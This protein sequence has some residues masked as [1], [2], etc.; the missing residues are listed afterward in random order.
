MNGEKDGSKDMYVK[1][2]LHYHTS[3]MPCHWDVNAYR[4]CGHGCR[5][6]FAQY[7]HEYIEAG[8]FFD[9]IFVKRNIAEILDKELGKK[10]WGKQRINLSGVTDAYQP[11]EA[12]TKLMPLIWKVLI[13]HKNPVILSTKSSLILRDIEL[14]SELASL[15]SVCITSSITIM[16]ENLRKLIEPGA[17]P[18]ED[19][20]KVLEAFGKVGCRT[21]VLLTPVMPGINDSMSNLETIYQKSSETGVTGIS[22]WPLNLRGNTKS[23]FF[24]FLKLHFPELLPR[25]QQLFKGW[26]VDKS[27]SDELREKVQLLR[28]KYGIPGVSLPP[29]DPKI[30][31]VQ[32]SLFD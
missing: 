20:F 6:C 19:R 3:E 2:A 12:T 28:E 13:K 25:Y 5:Y 23:R 17:A 15:T 32:L 21:S 24:S 30:A 16:D 14:I 11:L 18:T 22:P 10:S 9:H 26:H 4:G 29:E 31:V 1:S 8:N 27:Y 7:T